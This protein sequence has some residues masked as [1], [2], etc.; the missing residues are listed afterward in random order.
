ML[1][2]GS[3]RPA[4]D[5][6]LRREAGA[7]VSGVALDDALTTIV[8]PTVGRP[9]LLALLERLAEQTVH[10]TGPVLLV[11]DRTGS[12]GRPPPEW[13][14]DLP[15]PARVLVSGGRGPAAARNLG[16]RH[17]RTPWVSFVDDDV[18]PER[19]WYA[20]LLGDLQGAG[21][22]VVGSQGRLT[23]PLPSDRRPTDWERSTSGL[24]GARWITAD[25]TYRRD[26]LAAVGGFDERF[27]RAYREDIDLGL[28][29]TSG[30]GRVEWG[31]RRV[32]HPVRPADRWVS[33]RRQVGNADDALMRRL[34]GPHW[35]AR[36]HAPRGRLAVGGQ[37]D[38]LRADDAAAVLHV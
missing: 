11:D 25:L 31:Q 3:C 36:A 1:R 7:P 4:R 29:I 22:E 13:L 5:G 14:E 27:P 9:S 19:D 26:A 2:V 17:A 6:A 28:R 8:V 35:R 16:W 23:V 34:H 37:L 32:E 30:G 10:V 24:E 15:F 18:L 12:D 33:V 20:T 38:R 21:A